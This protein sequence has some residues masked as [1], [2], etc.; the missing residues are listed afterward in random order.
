[1]NKI[2]CECGHGCDY[3]PSTYERVNNLACNN[4]RMNT[5]RKFENKLSEENNKT[6]N[7]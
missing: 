7:N 1:M 2:K 5:F 4:S 3:K 6:V